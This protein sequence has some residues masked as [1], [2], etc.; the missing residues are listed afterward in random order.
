MGVCWVGE[1]LLEGLVVVGAVGGFEGFL[2]GLELVER[3]MYNGKAGARMR[4]A[5]MVGEEE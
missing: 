3:S 4:V 2:V 1:G 5:R